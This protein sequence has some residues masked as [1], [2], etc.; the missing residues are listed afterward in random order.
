[1]ARI[2]SYV[3]RYDSGFA[4]NPFYGYCTLATCKPNIRR[5]ADIGDWVVGSGSNDRTVRRGG[6]LVYAMRVTEAMTFDEYGADPRF[7]PKKPYRNGS[8]KQSCGDSIYFRATPEAAWQQRDS[9]HSR[10]DGTLNSDHV[11]RDTGVNRVLISNDFVYFG[12]E[13]PEFPKELKD[14]QNRPLCKTGIGLTT[15][16]DAQLIANLE[17]WI[18]SLDVSGYQGAPFEWLT[19]RG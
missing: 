8:R 6:H 11:A 3:V 2:H 7:E 9:F 17:Q 4:P 5:S 13:G 15:F 12:G 16:D 14:Q 19:L 10:S 1:M 18:R